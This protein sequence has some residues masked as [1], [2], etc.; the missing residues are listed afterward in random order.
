MTADLNHTRRA[1]RL[2]RW[3]PPA[4]RDRYGE[5]FVD[6]MEQELADTPRSVKRTANVVVK[7]LIA[8]LGDVGLVRPALEVAKPEGVSVATGFVLAAL[9]APLA[10]HY[11]S[12]AMIRWNQNPRWTS[13]IPISILTACATVLMAT[14]LLL[15]I[16]ILV[17]LLAAAGRSI[18]RGERSRIIGPLAV[19]LGSGSILGLTAYLSLTNLVSRGGFQ[20]TH[21]GNAIKQLAGIA[22]SATD[23]SSWMWN[24]PLRRFAAAPGLL[25]AALPMV[26]VAFALAVAALARRVHYSPTS[27]VRGRLIAK[28]LASSMALFMVDYLAWILAG[29]PDHAPGLTYQQ[30]VFGELTELIFLSLIATLA[31]R[32]VAVL[33]RRPVK[34]GA[35]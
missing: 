33:R 18:G 15:A 32:S 2:L 6:L 17:A 7:G 26:L 29:G 13:S 14:V 21:P 4:W 27:A 25:A 9:F 22:L 1:L 8:R 20:W 30:N 3:Y 35:D 28:L 23:N 31:L 16:G 24:S 11:W 10:L 12:D 34:V 5:E 19:I